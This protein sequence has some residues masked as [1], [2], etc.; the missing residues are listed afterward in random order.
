MTNFKWSVA[1]P[2]GAISHQGPLGGHSD[3]G[4]IGSFDAP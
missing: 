4:F 3:H 1:F 2:T